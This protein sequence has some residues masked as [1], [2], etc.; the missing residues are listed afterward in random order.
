MSRW[1]CKG[2]FDTHRGLKIHGASCKLIAPEVN[3]RVNYVTETNTEQRVQFFDS[4]SSFERNYSKAIILPW[5]FTPLAPKPYSGR[6]DNTSK[7]S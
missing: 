6:V 5:H 2:N 7:C 4:T 3:R 1:S